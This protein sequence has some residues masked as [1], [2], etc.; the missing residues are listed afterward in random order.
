MFLAPILAGWVVMYRILLIFTGGGSG[1][2]LRYLVE[3]WLQRL[4]GTSF[5]FGT[6]VVNL[7]G[8][9]I[10]GLLGGLFFGPRPINVD[11]RFAILTGVLG[12]YTTFST[13]AW[14][15]LQLGNDPADGLFGLR[16]EIEITGKR[17]GCRPAILLDC[18]NCERHE[19][20]VWVG[21]TV[22]VADGHVSNVEIGV[23]N[24]FLDL[25]FG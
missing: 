15:T 10:I 20:V 5:P 22:E 16:Q 19:G 2:V 21:R 9:L 1:S 3:G 11:Y 7:S 8:C 24:G 4:W 18:L 17:K 13:F 14:E 23:E 25:V 12:G 6:I